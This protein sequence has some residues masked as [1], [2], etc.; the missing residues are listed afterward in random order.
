MDAGQCDDD[1]YVDADR[2]Q[3]RISELLD[4]WVNTERSA[5][6]RRLRAA[7]LQLV[8]RVIASQSLTTSESPRSRAGAVCWNT[9]LMRLLP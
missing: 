1:W 7:S 5:Q 9:P 2:L 3:N 4:R 8:T 6:E